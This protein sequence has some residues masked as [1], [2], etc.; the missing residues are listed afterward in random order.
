MALQLFSG[1]TIDVPAMFIAGKSDWGAYQRP[2][3]LERMQTSACTDMRGCHLLDEAG[4][5]LQQEQ[6]EQMSELLRE[7]LRQ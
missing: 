4:H 3:N 5:W 6:R 2:G 1:R 7:F